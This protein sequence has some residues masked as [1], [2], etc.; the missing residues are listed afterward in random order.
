MS[1][2]IDIHPLRV[3]SQTSELTA[4]MSDT[5]SRAQEVNAPWA[6]VP[7]GLIHGGEIVLLWVKPSIWRPLLDS[8]PWLLAAAFFAALLT[9]G[10][11]SV[12][13]LGTALSA[14]IVVTVGLA[15]LGVAVLRWVPT[16]YLLTNLRVLSVRGVRSPSVTSRGLLEIRNTY[17]HATAFEKCGGIASIAFVT[18]HPNELPLVWHSV[19][20]AAEIH[21][22]IRRAIENAIDQHGLGT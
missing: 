1:L 5:P 17:V 11:L 13:G 8:G 4:T 15:R 12:S 22:R 10:N 2:A 16:W 19:P 3:P 20:N 18:D 7:G 6:Q 14:Q 9:L 21:Q